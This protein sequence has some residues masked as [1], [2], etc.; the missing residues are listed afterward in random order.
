M[1]GQPPTQGLRCRR[2]L[3]GFLGFAEQ[4]EERQRGPPAVAPNRDLCTPN[5]KVPDEPKVNLHAFQRQ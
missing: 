1:L 4:E 2:F 3:A 5:D